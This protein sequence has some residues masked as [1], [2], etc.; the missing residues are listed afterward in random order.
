MTSMLQGAQATGIANISLDGTVLDTWYPSPSIIDDPSGLTSGSRRVSAH[1]LGDAFLSLV[2]MDSDRLV[3]HVPVRTTIADLS[4]PPVDAHDVYLRLHLLSHRLVRPFEVNMEDCLEHLEPVVWTNKGPC[5]ADNFEFVRTRLRSR[6]NI[7]VYGIE[8]LP[9]MVDYVVPTG[10]SISEAERVRLGAYL[11]PGTTVVREGYVSHN[12]GALGPAKI[13]GRLSSAVTVGEG[14]EVALSAV[15]MAMRGSG[16]NRVPLRV[17]RNCVLHPASGVLG[18]DL[19]DNCEIG[20]NV[21]LEPSTIIYDTRNETHIP[22]S[23]IAGQS[24]I[25]ISQ[26]PASTTPVL[27]A[28]NS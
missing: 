5:L 20:V 15:L 19:G 28:R 11:A 2:G 24:D 8:R 17:G 23:E 25:T 6:G 21:M 4:Q 14:T 18:V 13:E 22:A 26:E 12:S 10:V 16:H 7:H 9:R 1:E 3:E 27:R